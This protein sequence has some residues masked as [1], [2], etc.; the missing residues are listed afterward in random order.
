MK[1]LILEALSKLDNYPI[2]GGA[3]ALATVI[4]E[5]MSAQQLPPLEGDMLEILGKPNFTVAGLAQRL[6]QLKLYPTHHKSEVEQATALHW[7]L[8]LYLKH[9]AA[10]RDEGEKILKGEP[11]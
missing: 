2:I 3:E 9:G 5:H 4:A 7:M 8:N 11:T 10:W 1:A 6:M